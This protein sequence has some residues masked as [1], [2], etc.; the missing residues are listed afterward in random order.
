MYEI[1]LR[2]GA[3]I[4]A[5]PQPDTKLKDC[6]LLRIIRIGKTK[7]LAAPVSGGIASIIPLAD[8]RISG[9]EIDLNRKEQDEKTGD[10]PQ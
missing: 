1:T 9:D 2:E 8:I 7:V 10:S 4:L 3:V 5:H 6:H